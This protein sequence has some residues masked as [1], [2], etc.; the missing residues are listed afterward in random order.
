MRARGRGSRD[1]GQGVPLT[2]VLRDPSGCQE[3]EGRSVVRSRGKRGAR[4]KGDQR[5]QPGASPRPRDPGSPSS[6]ARARFPPHLRPRE[7]QGNF[8]PAGTSRPGASH[9][10]VPRPPASTLPARPACPRRCPGP[11]SAEPGSASAARDLASHP[12]DGRERGSPSGPEAPQPSVHSHAARPGG[13]AGPVSKGERERRGVTEIRRPGGTQTEQGVGDHS[14]KGQWGERWGR[15]AGPEEG[16]TCSCQ[17]CG[18]RVF[19]ARRRPWPSVPGTRRPPPARRP[20][21]R[22]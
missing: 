6:C 3:G 10:R 19:C 21:R 14:V 7:G 20:G 15:G 12:A 4:G 16:G 8:P 18:E 22:P 13:S 5:V 17:P 11:R 9:Q 1:G 2:R